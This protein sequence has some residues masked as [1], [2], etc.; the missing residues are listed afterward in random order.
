MPARYSAL[1]LKHFALECVALN[2]EWICYGYKKGSKELAKFIQEEGFLQ[3]EGPLVVIFY[4]N[5]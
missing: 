5:P 1:K 4:V 2:F 3:I